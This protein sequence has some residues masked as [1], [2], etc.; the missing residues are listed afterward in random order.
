[1]KKAIVTGATGF[2]G[3][4]LVKELLERGV[5]VYAIIRKDSLNYRYL[6][7]GTFTVECNLNDFGMLPRLIKDRQIEVVFHTA[8]QGV[9]GAD[10]RN[11]RAQILNIESTLDLIDAAHEMG[12]GT[13]VG[14]GSIHEAEGLIEMAQDSTVN[15]LGY[16]YKGAKL[17]AHWMG[18]AKAGY[19]G[20]R[21]F[22][23]LINTYGEEERSVRLINSVIRSIFRGES[24][25]LSLGDQ[26]YDFV[27]VKD[28]AHALYLIAE[29]GIDGTNYTIGSGEAKKLRDFL[30]LVGE[31]ANSVNGGTNIPLGFGKITSNVTYLP[32]ET[33]D[34]TKL[35]QDTGFKIS[36]P[37]EQGIKQTAQWILMDERTKQGGLC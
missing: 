26:Y 1:M 4:Y 27:H 21:F 22:W 37:F 19:Y 2:I 33:F 13:F 18:K 34:V 6:P 25:D 11:Q 9:S 20:I 35:V 32:L 36:V 17:A 8:W 12:V 10:A 3:R 14:C 24:P 31:V 16:F 23:P 29:R 15:N 7:E 30:T 28:V 5:E